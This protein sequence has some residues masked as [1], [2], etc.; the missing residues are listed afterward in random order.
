MNSFD[1]R[2]MKSADPYV[3]SAFR[4]TDPF[5]DTF[6]KQ[7]TPM[8]TKELVN[9][10]ELSGNKFLE[11]FVHGFDPILSGKSCQKYDIT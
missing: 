11:Q 8:S 7:I 5:D 10:P 3:V 2:A 1:Q 9:L 6:M 4:G